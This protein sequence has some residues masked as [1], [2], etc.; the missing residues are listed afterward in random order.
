M[1]ILQKFGGQVWYQAGQGVGIATLSG[2]RTL[3]GT[4]AHFQSLN[5][6]GADRN[7]VL[8]ALG[9]NG[10]GQWYIARNTGTTYNL[11]VK[12]SDGSTTV[13]TVPPG[14]WVYIVGGKVSGSLDWYVMGGDVGFTSLTLLGTLTA[15]AG[16]FTGRL[17]TTDGVASGNARV[18]GGNVHTKLTSTTLTNTTTE[19]TLATHTLP[20]STLKAG[21]T[22]RVRGAVRVTGNA[23]ADTLTMKLRL[24]GT[25]IVTTAAVAMIANDIAR[26]D[27][28]ITSR[29][30]PSGTS[31]VV[32]EGGV[33][34]SVAG[35]HGAKGYVVAPANYATDGAL[36]VDLR[37]T[38]SAASASDIAICES[39]V[40]DVVA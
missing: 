14:S 33:T 31:A 23:S 4:S 29:A 1:G 34:I 5:P 20:A 18:V 21:T 9:V 39:F 13:A 12:K 38:W 37:G 10:H 15:V 36:D 27:F 24:G 30:A 17:T 22:L 26:F 35:T 7:L 8:P 2:T 32:A 19:T 6:S 40:V 11:V 25:A 16:V 28:L 3:S